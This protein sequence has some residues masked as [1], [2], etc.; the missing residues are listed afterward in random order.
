VVVVTKKNVRITPRHSMKKNIPFTLS[1]TLC[2]VCGFIAEVIAND[3]YYYAKSISD[4]KPMPPPTTWIFDHLAVWSN[5]SL[6]CIFLLPWALLV[7]FCALTSTG[8]SDADR[9]ARFCYG[10]ICFAL[11][12]ALLFVLVV[13]ISLMP[14]IPIHKGMSPEAPIAAYVP[15][16]LLLAVAVAIA[17]AT[18]IRSIRKP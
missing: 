17:V 11:S 8:S 10:F 5:G 3:L 14:F 4:G 16:F 18:V 1:L 12:E 9:A 7:L 13:F 15:H 6:I 2:L